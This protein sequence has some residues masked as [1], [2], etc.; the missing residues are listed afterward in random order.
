MKRLP[1]IPSAVPLP[2][3]M[4]RVVRRKIA[5]KGQAGTYTWAKRLITLD[6]D[7]APVPA[8][9]T[10][11]HEIVH[12]ILMDVGLKV[13]KHTEDVCNAIAAAKVAE[14]VSPKSRSRR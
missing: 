6:A 10:L 8:W 3:G 14:M 4:V 11:E 9:L 12:A 5:K 7:L 1:P 13:N 2:C